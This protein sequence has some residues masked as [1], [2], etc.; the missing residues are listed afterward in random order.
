MKKFLTITLA[1][2]LS[3]SV[4]VSCGKK[5]DQNNAESTVKDTGTTSFVETEN[6]TSTVTDEK[7]S[8]D[9]V[10][11]DDIEDD[12]TEDTAED[13]EDADDTS[14]TD[15]SFIGKWKN[16]GDSVEFTDGGKCIR[17]E[18][19]TAHEYEYIA[20]DGRIVFF[21]GNEPCGD[22]SYQVEGGKLTLTDEGGTTVYKK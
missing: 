14:K 5:K 9:T 22:A 3:L 11:V 18:D 7:K 10:D 2:F 19:G 8:R 21:D 6:K 4:L 12:E 1:A 15:T 16:G 20:E 17:T 13:T